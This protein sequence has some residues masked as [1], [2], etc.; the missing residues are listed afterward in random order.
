MIKEILAHLDDVII[1]DLKLYFIARELKDGYKVSDKVLD[2]YNFKA[3]QVDTNDDIRQ[4]LYD[5]T[6]DS[7]LSL[8]E[9][10]YEF[11]EYDV[12]GDDS[13]RILT[14]QL[15]NKSMS[16]N[17]VINNQ[18][19][20]GVSIPKIIG[21][22]E[23]LKDSELWAYCVG[24]TTRTESTV[25]T[26]RK[27]LRSKTAIDENESIQ[28]SKY[29]KFIRARFNTTSSKLEL[30]K[31]ETVNL[32]K[33]IDCIYYQDTFFF[34]SNSKT[35]FEQIIGLEEEYKGQAKAVAAELE[36]LNLISGI[37]TINEEI[38]NTPSIH[39]K[40]VRIARLGQYKKLDAKRVDAIIAYAKE[41][42]LELKHNNGKLKIEDKKDV[43]LVLKFL[44]D[45]FKD[46]K[47]T[48]ITYG[49]YAGKILTN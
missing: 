4:I 45:Y 22:N 48:G 41:K 10:N 7:M 6:T 34:G 15:Q 23:L 47:I 35:Q 30:I 25:Y 3:Y 37:D 8:S 2:K 39:K 38:E 13:P 19:K 32:D 29:Q 40:L 24:L 28:K 20:A 11:Q 33:K 9:K 5:Y 17:N 16:F 36:D 42:N 44:V 1:D 46:S 49:T 27:M 12:I 26:F 21:L 31:G 43:D 14:Y 18:L